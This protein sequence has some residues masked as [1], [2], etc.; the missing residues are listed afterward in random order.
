MKKIYKVFLTLVIILTLASCQTNYNKP[1]VQTD[2]S[3]T[4]FVRGMGIGVNIGNTLDCIGT[5]TW[6]AGETGWGNPK[7]T[8]EFIAALKKYGYTT[9]RLP[10]TWAENM[11]AGPNYTIAESWMSR[12]EEVVNWILAEDMYCILNLHHDGGE[13]DKSWILKAGDDPA[14]VTKQFAAVWKQ[15]ALRFSGA[16][17]K[18]ILEAMNEV[19]FSMWNQ[20]DASTIGKKPEAYRILNGLNQTFVDTVRAAGGKND[21]RFLLISGYY[22]D[23]DLT[24]D[25]L[26]KMPKDKQEDRLILSVHY[27]TPAVFCILD[28]DESWGKSQTDWG[29]GA[30]YAELS[31]QFEK[32]QKR[33]IDMGIPVIMG[34]YGV[35]FNNK[36]EEARTRWIT[37]VTQTCLDNGICPVFWDTGNDIKRSPSSSYEMSAA[38][39]E[40]WKNLKR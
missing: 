21:S 29:S 13:S 30:E 27:Y 24:C 40:V 38:L 28:K 2:N 18:L 5:N 11:G 4:E 1:A 7:I 10:V 37:A 36:L 12:V 39:K 16:Y 23:I 17:E 19:G 14:G 33:Y 35:N 31:R 34:E 6:L 3:A 15:I 25:P 8:R 20:W 22:T 9:I 32:I 26:F